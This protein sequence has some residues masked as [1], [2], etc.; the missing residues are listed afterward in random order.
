MHPRFALHA[1]GTDG[2]GFCR[3][4]LQARNEDTPVIQFDQP[5][6]VPESLL[7]SI[8]F[9]PSF[10]INQSGGDYNHSFLL[11]DYIIAWDIIHEEGSQGSPCVLKDYQQCT[12]VVGRMTTARAQQFRV[13]DS[14]PSSTFIYNIRKWD[15]SL[16][17]VGTTCLAFDSWQTFSRKS[18]TENTT[19]VSL[20]LTCVFLPKLLALGATSIPL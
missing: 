20:S 14:M 6:G 1:Q 3:G 17:T 9:K 8:E 12:G 5:N 11:T 10:V 2:R 18:Q 4:H 13:P 16:P 15:N 19:T 7:Q